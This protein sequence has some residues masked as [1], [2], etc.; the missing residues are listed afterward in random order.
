M[1]TKRIKHRIKWGPLKGMSRL[2]IQILGFF[3]LLIVLVTLFFEVFSYISVKNYYYSNTADTLYTQARYNAELYLSYLGDEDLMDVVVKN[4]NQFYRGNDA[5]VQILDNSGL[6]IYD[7]LGTE[8]VGTVLKTADV[9]E[10]NSGESVPYVGKVS[11]SDTPVMSVSYPLRSQV[12]QVGMLRLTT[13][14]ERVNALIRTRVILFMGFGL[15]IVLLA[16]LIG[17]LIARSITKPVKELTR[18]AQK[19]AD[20]QFQTRAVEDSN[21]EIGEL[22]RTMNFMSANI[23][24]KD[25]MKNEFISSISHELRTPLTSIKGWA[26]TLQGEKI[27][28]QM[29]EEGLK[30][31]EKESD[32]L[33]AMV[34]DLL[35][36][37][38]FSAGKVELAKT[39]FNIV[40]V[41]R[42]IISQFRPRS[43]E[44]SVDMLLNYSSE[45][46]E[47]IADAD[48]MKQ[49][50]LNILDNALKF[51]PEGGTIL[52]DVSLVK[53][54]VQITI[55]DTGV[56]I[57]EE[58]IGLVTEK[59]WKG[60]SS[61]SHT[62]LGLSICEE[63]IA[64]HGG[65]LQI[66]SKVGVGTT[67][68][69]EFPR[70]LA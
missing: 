34:E 27:P 13:S 66:T 65:E 5:Q 19:L 42:N 49:F 57:P 9:I 33:G 17:N 59:F 10:N 18:V 39:S 7:N 38:R 21:D 31:I 40:E 12:R 43:V 48:R 8:Q 51:T 41:A 69:A 64:A 56:G 68:R 55:T 54:H 61:G 52:T 24:K 22:A 6:V 1:E 4:K 29:N 67:V 46:I 28:P 30:I 70:E 37:S 47:V 16:I 44:K 53:E 15:I 36:F 14:L 45:S 26:I 35:D 20:G 62:G 11:Y 2:G 60:S 3:V 23:V 50:F 32:R 58:E 25:Q 63:I